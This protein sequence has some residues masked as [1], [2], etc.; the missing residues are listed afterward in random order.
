MAH[1]EKPKSSGRDLRKY[2]MEHAEMKRDEKS[3]QKPTPKNNT[4]AAAK[5]KAQR[6]SQSQRI[7]AAAKERQ[8]RRDFAPPRRGT[9]GGTTKMINGV[10][11]YWKPGTR[12]WQRV[13]VS[14]SNDPA[15]LADERKENQL[16]EALKT[17][18]KER[19]L[20]AQS[21]S[22][23]LKI[24]S[25]ERLKQLQKDLGGKP[26]EEFFKRWTSQV[27]QPDNTNNNKGEQKKNTNGSA[28]SNKKVEKQVKE[29]AAQETPGQKADKL[30][31]RID[32]QKNTPLMKRGQHR[33]TLER[34]IRRLREEEKKRQGSSA[35]TP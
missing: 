24:G 30:Q 8:T 14:R 20:E 22:E 19:R 5:R 4:T 27:R 29:G 2:N 16:T 9:A 15:D 6:K 32:K 31:K 28:E 21:R 13:G 1:R 18:K 33:S 26:S 25:D 35:Y 10:Q 3:K 11:Y 17:Q 12:E 34:K 7:Q 23:K